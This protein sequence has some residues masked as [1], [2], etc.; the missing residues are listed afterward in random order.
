MLNM[1]E[2]K[3]SN[4][5]CHLRHTH[6]YN[7]KVLF[8]TY[9]YAYLPTHIIWMC[10][11]IEIKVIKC[12]FCFLSKHNYTINVVNLVKDYRNRVFVIPSQP[13][14]I[15]CEFIISIHTRYKSECE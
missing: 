14:W 2:T 4:N 1:N 9:M 11:N 15:L 6:L 7:E 10:G 8:N 13:K 5:I 12:K 3:H